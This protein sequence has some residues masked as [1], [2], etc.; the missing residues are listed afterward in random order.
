MNTRLSLAALGSMLALGGCYY[1]APYAGYA[2]P[3]VPSAAT[4]REVPIEPGTLLSRRTLPGAP[5]GAAARDGKRDAYTDESRG[6]ANG[7]APTYEAQAPMYDMAPA[8]VYAV[9]P[10]PVYVP[11]A[12]PGYY[13]YPAYPVYP[14][15]Y[16][17]PAW[18]GPSVSLGF[19]FRFGG[20]GHHHHR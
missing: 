20:G 11:P 1:P 17:G 10:A 7:P 12:Y 19:G 4:Q 15:Y 6:D 2:T 3:A 9:P 8:P 18:W 16:G 5:P 14:A 13:P